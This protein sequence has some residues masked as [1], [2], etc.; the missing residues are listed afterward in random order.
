MFV[1]HIYIPAPIFLFDE[2]GVITRSKIEARNPCAKL[3]PREREISS[4]SDYA[5]LHTHTHTPGKRRNVYTVDSCIYN[6]NRHACVKESIDIYNFSRKSSSTYFYRN[7]KNAIA[8]EL[9]RRLI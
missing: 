4:T 2:N 9:A 6:N 1:F 3:L 8:E 5:T 7:Q